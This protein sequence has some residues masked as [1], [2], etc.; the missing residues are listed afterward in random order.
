[1]EDRAFATYG[2]LAGRLF[3]YPFTQDRRFKNDMLDKDDSDNK[4]DA[5][6]KLVGISLSQTY[7]KTTI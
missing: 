1:M 2:V 4:D 5:M 3:S 6:I 7:Q